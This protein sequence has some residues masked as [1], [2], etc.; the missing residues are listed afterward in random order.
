MYQFTNKQE[1]LDFLASE[2]VNTAE[3]TAIM[4]TNRQNVDDMVRRGKLIPVKVFPRD[5]V[6][7]KSD[8]IARKAEIDAYNAKKQ[9]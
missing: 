5:R 8:V 4:E 2:L 6:F 7:L 1:L 9:S 3:A